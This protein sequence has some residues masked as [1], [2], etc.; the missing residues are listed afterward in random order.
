M[1]TLKLF[2]TKYHYNSTSL[3]KHISLKD[4]EDLK[5]VRETMDT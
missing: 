3:A 5:V 4:V 2:S 1:A